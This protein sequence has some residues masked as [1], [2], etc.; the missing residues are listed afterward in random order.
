MEDGQVVITRYEI[1][2]GV[3]QGGGFFGEGAIAASA[4]ETYLL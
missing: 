4:D 3:I 1:E 2:I